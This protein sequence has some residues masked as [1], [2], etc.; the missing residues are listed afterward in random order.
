[1]H[2]DVKKSCQIKQVYYFFYTL[3]VVYKLI[4]RKTYR[5]GIKKPGKP[6]F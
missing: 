4:H 6:G 1:M 2:R 3:T 5:T